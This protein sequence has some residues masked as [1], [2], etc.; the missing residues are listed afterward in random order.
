MMK[1]YATN[2]NDLSQI[3]SRKYGESLD[4]TQSVLEIIQNVQA[5]K[6]EALFEYTARFDQAH[7]KHLKVSQEELSAAY[8]EVSDELLSVMK[9]AWQRILDFHQK[10]KREGF[11]FTKN[12][13]VMG[14][15]ILPLAKVGVYVPGGTASYPSTVLMDVAPAKVAGVKEIVLITPPNK[16]G[17][18]NP[19]VLVAA[20]IAGVDQIFKVGGAHGIAA[21]AYGTQ[22]I[23]RVDK[24]VGPGNI[25]VATAK[26]LVYG[27][28]DIDMIAGPS[29]I[30]IIANKI[31]PEHLEIAVN[32]PFDYLGSI[33]NAGS[34]FL[35]HYTPEVLGDYLAGPNHTLP[36]EGT[37]RFYS[38]LSVDDF[39]KRSSYLYFSKA[40]FAELNQQVQI[41]AQAEGLQGHANSAKVREE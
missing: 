3:L 8:Q 30:L 15:R 9:L 38:A 39:V 18:V 5:R 21:L 33:Q 20:D 13:E 25:Y 22:T 19:A 31:A 7:L 12:G 26:R 6:D 34:I 23:P 1:E 17:K 4:V 16:E 35:G 41:F 24:I 36:T 37:A 10:Q 29:D 14:Q 11:V 40:H 28:V 32:H 27:Q 2:K